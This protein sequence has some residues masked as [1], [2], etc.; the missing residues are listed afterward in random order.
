MKPSHFRYSTSAYFGRSLE[1]RRTKSGIKYWQSDYPTPPRIDAEWT[2]LAV[3][4]EQWQ[5]FREKIDRLSKW[6]AKYRS[7]EGVLD[8]ANWEVH[9]TYRD[10]FKIKSEGYEAWPEDFVVFE[11]ALRE[12]RIKKLHVIS[13]PV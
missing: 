11:E 1:V 8:G 2:H 4:S 5:A 13:S 9:I 6:E 7:D 12:L 3:S 10:E